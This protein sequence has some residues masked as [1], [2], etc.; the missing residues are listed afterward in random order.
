MV[1]RSNPQIVANSP[2]GE[3]ET[4]LPMKA[5]YLEGKTGLTDLKQGK[6]ATVRIC[7]EEG[8]VACFRQG[9]DGT[10]GTEGTDQPEAEGH[11]IR[12]LQFGQAGA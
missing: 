4:D 2:Y 7:R 3:F 5:G 12:R 11:S 1:K 6:F 10:N 9:T 8:G